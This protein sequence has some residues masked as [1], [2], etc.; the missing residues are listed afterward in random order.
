MINCVKIV[1]DNVKKKNSVKSK[2]YQYNLH[3]DYIT[4]KKKKGLF[5]VLII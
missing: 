1:T 4:P 5:N 2:N 3:Q